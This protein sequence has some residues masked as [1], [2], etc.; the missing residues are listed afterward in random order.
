MLFRSL[1][2]LTPR[3]FFADKEVLASDSE[4][5]LRYSGVLVAGAGWRA[6]GQEKDTNIAF[7]YAGESYVDFGLPLM[8][9]PI[10]VYGFLMGAVY[11]GLLAVIWH[12]ELAIALVTVVFW[13]SLYLFERSWVK[14]LGLSVTLV[15]YLGGATLLLD[16]FLLWR[17]RVRMGLV[18]RRRGLR[19]P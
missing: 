12:R 14:M 9:L 2:L 5:V 17:R 18:G 15:L 7:G 10:L 8:F 4:M 6:A 3:L 1:H 19:V 16:R 11:R 13:L